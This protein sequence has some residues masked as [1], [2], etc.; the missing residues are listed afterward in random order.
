MSIIKD[1]YNPRA[2][3]LTATQK[4]ILAI[5]YNAPTP[6]MAYE[7]T[8]GSHALITARNIL[9]RLGLI[10]L[11]DNKAA[12]TQDGQDAVRA[13]NI[14]DET[15]QITDEGS[16]LIDSINSTRTDKG[17]VEDFKLLKSL[18]S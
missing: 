17:L 5:L 3:V 15:G 6:E 2:V 13:N 14:A 1:S 12:L 11:G 18:I 4:G 8:N 9:E 10:I 7:T 16:A